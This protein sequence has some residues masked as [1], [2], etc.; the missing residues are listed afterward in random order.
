MVADDSGGGSVVRAVTN[1]LI[2]MERTKPGSADLF[3]RSLLQRLARL[4]AS[5]EHPPYET[6]S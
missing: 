1:S 4:E 2:N 6:L 5:L 3:V